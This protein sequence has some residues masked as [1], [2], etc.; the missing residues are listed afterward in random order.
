MSPK[1][2]PFKA[3]RDPT[4]IYEWGNKDTERLN[5]LF[6]D[7]QPTKDGTKTLAPGSQIPEPSPLTTV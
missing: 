6:D 1:N 2:Y 3:P 4:E 7:T 5:N